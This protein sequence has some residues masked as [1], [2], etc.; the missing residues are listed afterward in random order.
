MY[1]QVHRNTIRNSQ[2][3]GTAQRPTSG[4][5]DKEAVVHAYKWSIIRP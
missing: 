4:W 1:I 2:E 3:V 5:L